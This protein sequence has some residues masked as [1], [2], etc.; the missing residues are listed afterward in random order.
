MKDFSVKVRK[1]TDKEL[2]K[3]ACEVTFLGTS[4]QTLKSIYRSEHSPVRTQLFWIKMENIPLFASTH[5]IRHHVGS[6][7][8]Q[9][10]CRDDRDGGNPGLIKKIDGML[11]RLLEMKR[12]HENNAPYDHIEAICLLMAE[13]EW[14]Q[15]NSDRYTP[16][17]LAILV[18]AQSLIDMAKLRLCNQASKETRIIFNAIKEK[19]REVDPAL[20]NMMVPKCVYRGGICSEPH[21]C[22]H[23]L[24]PDFVNELKDYVENMGGE[25]KCSKHIF[26]GILEI[27]K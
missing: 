2:M 26:A 17:N 21:C 4:H 12:A 27:P 25:R 18:N 16:V 11:K 5:L 23:I 19:I 9:L 14:L 1:L 7:P 3:E 24:T 13:L 8:F 15:E 22:G 6:Q 20:A 10:T